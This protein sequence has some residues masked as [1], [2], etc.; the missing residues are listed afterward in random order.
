MQLVNFV[1][2]GPPQSLCRK[3]FF[4][5]FLI[6]FPLI[7]LFLDY[8]RIWCC[9]LFSH[10]HYGPNQEIFGKKH[11]SIQTLKWPIVNTVFYPHK[12]PYGFSYTRGPQQVSPYL[13]EIPAGHLKRF[14]C[15]QYDDV[16]ISSCL[17]I[18]LI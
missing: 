10:Q 5:E 14:P 1:H 9:Y 17:I 7:L 2:H 12:I 3:L 13:T 11:F 4:L 18:L 6:L 8:W 16:M 15:K